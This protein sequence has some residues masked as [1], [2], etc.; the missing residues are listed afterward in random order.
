MRV[1]TF[2]GTRPEIIKLSRVIPALDANFEHALVHTG[3]NWDPRL[4]DVFFDE[5]KLRKP[6]II[7]PDSKHLNAIEF[8]GHAMADIYSVLGTYK[9]DAVLILGD[10]NS[11][12]GAAYA[13]KRL[14]IPVFHMEAGNR[15]FDERTPEEINRRII[16]TIADVNMPYTEHA[17]R[18]L[19]AMGLPEERIV[20]TG[21][22]MGEV[23][24]YFAPEIAAQRGR[25]PLS[26]YVVSCHREENVDD[27][28]RVSNLVDA[29][30]ALTSLGTVLVSVHPRLQPKLVKYCFMSIVLLHQPFGF[31]EYARLQRDACC[32]ISDSGTLAEE[33]A[34]LKFP[35]V[36]I[37]Y[38]TERPEAFEDANFVLSDLQVDKVLAAVKTAVGFSRIHRGIPVDY[39][40]ENVSV[41]VVQAIASLT[42]KVKR[43]TWR[44]S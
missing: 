3:Q 14:H 19:L 36:S 21:S 26:Y 28:R 23:L 38:A 31:I 11:A 7:L 9:P 16:D 39:Q 17:R 13:A 27:P 40:D 42:D 33:A 34:L 20:K 15:C 5:L 4:K 22:P 30:N 8:I 41:K 10:T 29:I 35:A 12:V 18:N 32:V 43:D 2:V 25:P 37:R 6:N 44:Q 24:E 1:M